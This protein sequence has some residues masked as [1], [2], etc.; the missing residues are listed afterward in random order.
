MKD[1]VAIVTGASRGIGR[2]TC[3]AL[4]AAGAKVVINYA[5][6]EAAALETEKLCAAEGVETLVIKGDVSS[7]DDCAALVAATL[8][9]FGRVDILVNNAGITKDNILMRMSDEE[10][11]AV[12]A[13]NLRGAYLMMKAVARP[14]MK[15]KYGRIINMASVVGVMGNAGQVNYAASKGG[16]IS[17]TKSF[18]REIALKGVT[19]NA[20]A[21][22]FIATDMT[23][24]MTDAAKEAACANI[25]KKEI[26]KPE[27]VAEAVKFFASEKAGYVT[28]QVL[29]VDGGMCMI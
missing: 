6:N 11:D 13:T 21:P 14:M 12:I 25:P 27:D 29:C 7:A 10:F 16:V 19:V 17:M 26:G 18:A 1:K 5:G 8:E 22:G 2:A 4:A 9:K 20:V 15:Q 24:E 3:V 28:G 23:N